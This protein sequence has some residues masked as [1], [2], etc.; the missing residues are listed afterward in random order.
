M[1][2]DVFFGMAVEQ[3]L[4]RVGRIADWIDVAHLTVGD[5]ACEQ[6]L[7]FRADLMTG[8]ERVL[9]G[10]GNFLILFSTLGGSSSRPSFRNRV[11]PDQCVRL[12][13]MSSAS[14]EDLGMRESCASR[15]GRKAEIIGAASSR[16]VASHTSAMDL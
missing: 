13:R 11:R 3:R 7:V 5:R 14:L 4:E 15:E 9:A 12:Y 6:R 10:L 1:V 2:I 8:E 16:R